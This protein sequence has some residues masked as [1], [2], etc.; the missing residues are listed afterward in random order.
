[1]LHS[2]QTQD[3]QHQDSSEHGV[4]LRAHF[5]IRPLINGVSTRHGVEEMSEDDYYWPLDA[6]FGGSEA[7]WLPSPKEDER[8]HEP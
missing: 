7:C 2:M 8:P 1:M 5:D 6:A 4:S 3:V